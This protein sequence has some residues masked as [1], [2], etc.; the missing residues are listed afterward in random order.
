MNHYQLSAVSG[1]VLLLSACTPV[2]QQPADPDVVAR[3]ERICTASG[4]FKLVNG[5]VVLAVP[6]AA[7]PI[8]LLNAGVDKVCLDPERF[9]ADA[10]TLKWLAKNL[11]PVHLHAGS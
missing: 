2:Q 6:A 9:A 11:G 3:I 7:I 5:A 8:A 1:I 10:A 4:F